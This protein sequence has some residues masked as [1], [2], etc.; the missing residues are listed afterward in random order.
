MI[1][2]SRCVAAMVG[3]LL[4]LLQ[5]PAYAQDKIAIRYADQ[6]PP[7]HLL[8]RL[9]GQAFKQLIEE[10][11]NGRVEVTLYPGEQLAKAAGMLDA[12]KNNIADIGIVGTVYI[13]D[14]MPLTSVVE[15]PGLFDNSI[16]GSAAGRALVQEFLLER[17]YLPNG[18]RPL[19][20]LAIPPY[21]LMFTKEN[22]LASMEDISGQKLRVSGAVSE[23]VAN[24]LGAVPVKMS[25]GDLYIG[26]QRGTV[27]GAIYNPPSVFGY[28]IEELLGTVTRNASL[29]SATFVGMVNERFWQG[30]PEDIRQLI[31]EVSDEVNEKMAA[32]FQADT[33]ASYEQLESLGIKIVDLSPEMMEEFSNRLSGVEEAWITQM[34]SR[35]L[36][37]EETLSTFKSLLDR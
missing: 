19:W 30:L 1:H 11:S 28:K 14:R 23:F 5:G 22:Q 35:G 37:A 27:D 33:D 24:V 10:R 13:T 9:S 7:T 32:G 21:Q 25:A 8:S 17:E 20:F 18:V 34:N 12:I 6:L 29:G 36:P 26:L 16:T 15:L 2:F 3:V 31:L 4:A